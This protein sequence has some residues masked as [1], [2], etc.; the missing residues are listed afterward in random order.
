MGWVAG[1]EDYL[2][3]QVFFTRVS[4]WKLGKLVSKLVYFTSSGHLQPTYIGWFNPFTKYH[5]HPSTLSSTRIWRWFRPHRLEYKKTSSF[6]VCILKRPRKFPH[7]GVHQ[8]TPNIVQ[9]TPQSV[10]TLFDRNAGGFCK[11]W[12]CCEMATKILQMREVSMNPRCA[13]WDWTYLPTF[14]IKWWKM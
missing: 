1:L 9:T 12:K 7:D 4:G 8:E 10:V 3:I 6:I 5:G 14:S 13:E 2:I 11:I